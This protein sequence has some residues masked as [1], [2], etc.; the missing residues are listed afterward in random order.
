MVLRVDVVAAAVEGAYGE[1]LDE[2]RAA[3]RIVALDPGGRLLDDA[4]AR[5]LAASDRA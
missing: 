3:R 5:E 4:Y 2:V 1:P